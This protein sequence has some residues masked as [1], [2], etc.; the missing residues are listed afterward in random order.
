MKRR[1]VVTGLGVLSPL[2]N[3]LKDTWNGVLNNKNGIN[4]ITHFDLT[5]FT[6]TTAGEL[7]DFNWQ[8][9]LDKREGKRLDDFARY[10]LI[11]AGEALADSKLDLE[12]LDTYKMGTYVTSGIGGLST[13]DREITKA[14]TDGMR[15][16]SPF[17]IPSAIINLGAGNIAIKYG[18]KGPSLATVT[19]CASSADVIGQAFRAIRDGY[20]EYAIAGGSEASVNEIG[21]SGFS[22]M[23]AVTTETDV[24]KASIPFD[25][26]RSGFVMGEGSAML[27]LETLENA[28]ARGAHIYAEIIG[29]GATND[30]SHITA[31]SED[32]EGATM[33]MLS[34]IK[35]ANLEVKDVDYV[36]AHGTSTPLN[37]KT[38][39][40]AIKT[41]F[42][43][44][45]YNLKVSSTKSMTGHLL[46][47]AGA[48]EAL[49]CIKALEEGFV[50]ATINLN[51]PDE[52]FDL[53]YVPNKGIKKDIKVA[54]SNSL[55]FGG[56]NATLV[57]R[58][59]EE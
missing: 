56:H 45:A 33:C 30:A 15:F 35:D 22:S 18:I 48:I 31:P 14:R 47:A 8:D 54:L 1:V 51:E 12:N 24:N 32:G 43:D 52:G 55:G 38:E 7:K 34:A 28:K 53:D 25:K 13:L 27:I 59:Y 46:G 19:A 29:Y 6:V 49:L 40:Q 26:N 39:T 9:Y 11:A 57:F 20:L 5:G 21:I 42:K 41:A 36:N 2:G 17:F 3:N 44:H 50:P 4:T 37:D 16:I 58:K 23:R 10:A